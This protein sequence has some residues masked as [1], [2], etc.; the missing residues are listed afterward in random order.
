M[1]ERATQAT[2]IYALGCVG[3][4]LLTGD[5]PF[6]GGPAE[7][8][9]QH[10]SVQPPVLSA[11]SSQ[12]QT[13]LSMMLRKPPAARP[14]LARV[15]GVLHGIQQSPPDASPND[16]LDRLAAAAAQHERAEAQRAAE[17]EQRNTVVRHRNEM[18]EAART[19]LLAV[20]GEL[21]RRITESVP[22]ADVRSEGSSHVI[23]VGSGVLKL[24]LDS[25]SHAYSE[26]GFPRSKW[27]VIWGAVLEV[28][29]SEPMHQRAASLWYTRQAARTGDYR[30]YEV[31]YQGNPLTGKGFRFEPAAV[32]PENADRAHWHGM[33]VVQ[34]CYPPIPI[35]DE[36][37]DSFCHRWTHI[38]AEACNGR[39]QNLPQH[40]P[41]VP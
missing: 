20:F 18:A 30:W 36:D 37:I 15:K 9:E 16:S 41:P 4:A 24:D 8:Q 7:L 11:V 22:N 28:E 2:D 39:L 38:L 31:G 33:D 23:R 12:F 6:S 14:S 26:D 17:Q 27:D 3:Y 21:A 40:L 10:L 19:T 13:L 32:T 34:A 35:D 1:L 5:P 25:S 29:Q